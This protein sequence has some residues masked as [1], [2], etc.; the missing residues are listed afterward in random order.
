MRWS[1]RRGRSRSSPAAR[2]GSGWRWPSASPGPGCDLVIADVQD[3]ALAAAT[4]QLQARGVEVLPVR[5]DVSKEAEVQASPQPTIDR[6]GAVHVVCNNAGVAARGRSVVRPAQLVGVGDGRQLLGRRP[7][8]PRVPPAPRRR[9]RAHRQHG[10][11]RRAVPRASARA[12]TRR[13]TPSWR[14]PSSSTTRSRSPGCRSASACCARAGCAPTSSRPTATGRPSSAPSPTTTRRDAVTRQHIER[15]LAEGRTPASVA[16]A[17]ADAV[18]ADRF[19]V[20]PHQDFL[21]LCIERWAT[22]AE[23]ARPAAARGR[24]GHAAA[25]ADPRR[26]RRRPRPRGPGGH[27]RP[28]DRPPTEGDHGGDRSFGTC[29]TDRGVIFRGGTEHEVRRARG[30]FTSELSG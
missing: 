9:R 17:V 4:A 19:W 26:G 10:L 16:D 28:L 3:D 22:I 13:S 11:D 24:A 20:I 5:V 7:R 27:R 18:T 21:D 23:R 25:V 29:R 14:S 15:A 12:T 2:A 6:F 1:S 8:L 30:A